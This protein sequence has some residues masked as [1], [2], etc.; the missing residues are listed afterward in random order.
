MT[1][2]PTGQRFFGRAK[3]QLST[4]HSSRQ[5]VPFVITYGSPLPVFQYLHSA[6]ADNGSTPETYQWL[7]AVK[8]ESEKK[9][10]LGPLENKGLRLHKMM[11][12]KFLIIYVPLK[13]PPQASGSECWNVV[14][15][16][17][18]EIIA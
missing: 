15:E 1:Q 11:N 8:M 5:E 13:G 6:L 7:L 18:S 9:F 10:T 14:K 16:K 12:T 3:A 2:A 17:R 4:H